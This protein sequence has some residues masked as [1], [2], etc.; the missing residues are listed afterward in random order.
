MDEE[1]ME[2]ETDEEAM[3]VETENSDLVY[4]PPN[5]SIEGR[6]GS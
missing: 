2:V 6:A 4:S 3:E 5:R 1:A